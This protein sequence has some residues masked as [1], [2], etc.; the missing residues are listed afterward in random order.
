MSKPKFFI[1]RSASGELVKLLSW[2]T[3]SPHPVA[4]EVCVLPKADLVA[5][6][7]FLIVADGPWSQAKY[8]FPWPETQAISFL[9]HC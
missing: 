6:S 9:E 1:D 7:A 5:S 3:K 2:A 4:V 8:K